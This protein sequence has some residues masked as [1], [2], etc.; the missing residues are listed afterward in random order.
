MFVH[1]SQVPSHSVEP[2][3]EAS[4]ADGT[5]VEMEPLV[6]KDPIQDDNDTQ[7]LDTKQPMQDDKDTQPLDTKQPMQDE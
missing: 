6:K 7:P 5:D 1:F 2:T 4:P 3:E